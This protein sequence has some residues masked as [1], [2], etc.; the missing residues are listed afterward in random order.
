MVS[1]FEILGKEDGLCKFK[2]VTST[3]Q[4][5]ELEQTCKVDNS[6][7]LERIM[8]GTYKEGECVGSL[9]DSLKAGRNMVS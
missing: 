9:A 8:G 2:Q 5:G 3:P 1:Y 7:G 4:T 6:L